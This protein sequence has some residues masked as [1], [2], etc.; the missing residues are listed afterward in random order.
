MTDLRFR[1]FLQVLLLFKVSTA[2]KRIPVDVHFFPFLE[3]LHRKCP[4]RTY[5]LVLSELT[6]SFTPLLTSSTSLFTIQN[7]THDSM[8]KYFK[9]MRNMLVE[10]G[11]VNEVDRLLGYFE[12]SVNLAGSLGYL[13][14]Y[15][16]WPNDIPN[17]QNNFGSA[18]CLLAFRFRIDL[19]ENMSKT[20]KSNTLLE[21]SD[22][23]AS[24]RIIEQD[25]IS[26]LQYIRENY[27]SIRKES[28]QLVEKL[29]KQMVTRSFVFDDGPVRSKAISNELS[30]VI[31]SSFP[32]FQIYDEDK[33][34]TF[35]FLLSLVC[36]CRY[37]KFG[38]FP[39]EDYYNY[40]ARYKIAL[41][42]SSNNNIL[43]GIV[44]SVIDKVDIT[45]VYTLEAPISVQLHHLV[46][47]PLFLCTTIEAL[48]YTLRLVNFLNSFHINCLNIKRQHRITRLSRDIY[49]RLRIV[50][51]A[52]LDK[53]KSLQCPKYDT[54][55]LD[56]WLQLM[57]A[58]MEVDVSTFVPTDT[59]ILSSSSR[60]IL[61]ILRFY[62]GLENEA[63]KS[64]LMA[65]ISLVSNK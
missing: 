44:M 62:H 30:N 20:S 12:K 42:L 23:L 14:N 8:C 58:H 52:D 1:L 13:L 33:V 60:Y 36:H 10:S 2:C 31:L 39:F 38:H 37:R 35:R 21:S 43:H 4:G 15:L 65:F 53:F 17:L 32:P 19:I 9:R 6:N 49:Q 64:R 34:N 47:V 24:I 45:D 5:D 16:E 25:V 11:C 7:S 59:S 56:A 50:L 29:F 40:S 48:H 27:S 3:E 18:S 28:E 63:I 55:Q 57:L 22:K 61:T 41:S 46:P 51:Q 54:K 26:F